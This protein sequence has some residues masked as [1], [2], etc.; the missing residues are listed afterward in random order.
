MRTVIA[1]LLGLAFAVGTA[2]AGEFG[3]WTYATSKGVTLVDVSFAG[4]GVTQEAQV[5]L[6][7]PAGVRVVQ[8]KSL[9]DGAVCS[10]STEA[11]MA[12]AVP[13]SGAGAALPSEDVVYCRFHVVGLAFSKVSPALQSKFSECVGAANVPCT[14]SVRDVSDRSSKTAAEG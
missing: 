2:E 9:V 5:D 6:S 11:G 1:M 13:P 4:D 12:R 10:A 7:L 3:V 8:A 14:V